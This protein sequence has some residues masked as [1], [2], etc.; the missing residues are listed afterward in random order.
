MDQRGIE[1]RTDG[2][3]VVRYRAHA[4]HARRL[5]RGPWTP[6][7]NEALKHREELLGDVRQ[8]REEAL[9]RQGMTYNGAPWA[10]VEGVVY[11]VQSGD[12]IKIGHSRGDV[13]DRVRSIQI[14][15][16]HEVKLLATEPGSMAREHELHVQFAGHRVRGEWFDAGPVLTYLQTGPWDTGGNPRTPDGTGHVSCSDRTY[17]DGGRHKPLHTARFGA[18]GAKGT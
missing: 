14:E 4:R 11:F 8:G 7:L 16:A 13:A 17:W 9:A 2:S 12:Y 3:G 10:G 15:N 6:D 5:T 18:A 1:Q